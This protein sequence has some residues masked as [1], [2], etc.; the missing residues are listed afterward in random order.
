MRTTDKKCIG[1]KN[2][3]CNQ[4]SGGWAVKQMMTLEHFQCSPILVHF[5]RLH[6]EWTW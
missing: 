3:L 4:E 5:L 2:S 6:P 1:L